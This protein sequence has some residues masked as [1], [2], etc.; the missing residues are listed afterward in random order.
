MAENGSAIEFCHELSCCPQ[1]ASD[2]SLMKIAIAS[3]NEQNAI[4]LLSHWD[5]TINNH[6]AKSDLYI[7]SVVSRLDLLVEAFNSNFSIGHDL[8]L[9]AFR[10]ALSNNDTQMV[11]RLLERSNL[12]NYNPRLLPVEGLGE[13]CPEMI[14]YLTTMGVDLNY[15][16]G[17]PLLGAVLA[18]KPSAIRQLVESGADIYVADN[19]AFRHAALGAT[20]ECLKLLLELAN[21]V[22]KNG[23]CFNT[24]MWATSTACH[25]E[26]LAYQLTNS[27]N[28]LESKTSS[29]RINLGE[30]LNIPSPKPK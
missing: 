28:Q 30:F 20:D 12:A 2:L 1:F 3:G 10:V 11:R 17:Q 23:A 8:Q 21:Y 19:A 9:R 18:R 6:R 16:N 25:D 4:L 7:Q 5:D 22:D 15:G 29:M 13:T 14:T 27:I 26:I 24:N